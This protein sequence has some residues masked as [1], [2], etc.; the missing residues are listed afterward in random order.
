MKNGRVLINYNLCDNAPECSGIAVCPTGALYYDDE[1]ERER[2]A[3]NEEL[4]CDCGA[5]ADADGEG[6]P[7]GAILHANDDEEYAQM[8]AEIDAETRTA[9]ALN[10]ERYGASPIEEILEVEQWEDFVNVNRGNLLLL[11]FFT[12]NSIHCL[13]H[14]IPI[15]SLKEEIGEFT[16]RKVF[17]ENAEVMA[18]IKVISDYDLVGL[19]IL[20]CFRDGKCLG[21]VEGYYEDKDR[22]IFVQKLRE[23][24]E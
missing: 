10:V 14:S 3:F 9:K 20:V 5:C 6:C 2:I 18:S 19:P 16:H 11:E 12:D 1:A 21:V 17:V 4:C 7:I 22:D 8:R 23:I 13:L 15:S 24:V